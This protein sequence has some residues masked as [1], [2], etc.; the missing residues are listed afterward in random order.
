MGKLDK[1]LVNEFRQKFGDLL[2][3]CDGERRVPKAFVD[4]GDPI[5]PKRY[6]DDTD[7]V[8]GTQ[9]QSSAYKELPSLLNA[10]SNSYKLD[11][12][13]T[14]SPMVV[15][16]KKKTCHDRNLVGSGAVFH[17]QA[18]DLHSPITQW[19]TTM[20]PF[21]DESIENTFPSSWGAPPCFRPQIQHTLLGDTNQGQLGYMSP[22]DLHSLFSDNTAIEVIHQFS[23]S[24]VAGRNESTSNLTTSQAVASSVLSHDNKEQ[25]R[26]NVTLQAP[27]AMLQSVT[28]RA[29]T[30]LNKSHTYTLSVI[31][32]K[33]PAKSVRCSEYKTSIRVAFE[34]E[35]QR[36]DPIASW[37][38]WK[39][40]RGLDEAY[41]RQSQL[42]AVEFVD[43]PQAGAGN[44]DY[45]PIRL[46]KSSID[47]FCITW[48]A[49]PDRDIHQCTIPLRFHFLSTDFSRAKGV[50]GVP[51]RLCAKTNSVRPVGGRESRECDSEICYCIV[52]LFR[53]HGAERKMSN[54][55]AHIMKKI[56]KL[57]QKIDNKERATDLARPIHSYDVTNGRQ[58]P[59]AELALMHEILQSARQ[60]SVLSLRGED[61][62]D[63]DLYPV[64]LS[65]ETDLAKAE[66][67]K[68]QQ[69][70]ETFRPPTPEDPEEANRLSQ[71]HYTQSNDTQSPLSLNPPLEIPKLS[72]GA[73]K[74]STGTKRS[75]QAVACFY[76]QFTHNGSFASRRHHAIYL[77]NRT[78]C[79][80]QRKLAEKLQIDLGAITCI[81]WQNSKGLKVLVDDD[82]VQYLPEGQMMAA[83]VRESPC[84]AVA[85]AGYEPLAMEIKLL[86]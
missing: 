62:D 35:E 8:D 37:K 75:S 49:N 77:E 84:T 86:F 33:S 23:T 36:S 85:F 65:I 4:L 13:C 69:P 48:K 47:G 73:M 20:P 17:N 14:F 83:V 30:Y 78:S 50:K 18:G 53:D 32:S 21:L 66:D 57:H 19:E 81:F 25:L 68:T 71:E 40:N 22:D 38:L 70:N 46:E 9:V 26:Y 79:D 3:N 82:T 43:H 34:E 59:H 29:I 67:R 7:L 60:E 80:L 15:P 1:D 5:E 64:A 63:P 61:K 72:N 76:V 28:E 16:K 44:Q 54:D 52:K 55:V 58:D 74:P 11:T 51:V 39:E 10:S 6:A 12:P 2:L 27:T 31:V 41:K 45:Q 56:D 42:A 24:H